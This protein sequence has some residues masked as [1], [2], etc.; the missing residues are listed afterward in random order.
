MMLATQGNVGAVAAIVGI[1]LLVSGTSFGISRYI[2]TKNTDAAR[3]IAE[4]RNKQRQLQSQAAQQQKAQQERTSKLEGLLQ[5]LEDR[6]KQTPTDSMLVISAA[7]MAYDLQQYQ[8][9]ETYY[10]MFLEK[11]DPKN[12]NARIDLAFVV[13]Q[14]GRE[15]EGLGILRSVIGSQ[16]SNQTALYNA[17]YLYSQS[18]N[19]DSAAY[20]LETCVRVDPNSEAGRNA[21]AVLQQLRTQPNT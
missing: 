7:N 5:E 2:V 15:A 17:A 12:V 18:G 16:P 1:V 19:K 6:M 9:A 13:F 21:A 11:I 3:P 10:R 8:K 4:E 14:S 20:F